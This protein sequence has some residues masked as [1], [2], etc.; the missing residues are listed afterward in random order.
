MNF[1]ILIFNPPTIRKKGKLNNLISLPFFFLVLIMFSACDRIPQ[2]KIS[3]R[4]IKQF[5]TNE[6]KVQLEKR[7]VIQ[8]EEPFTIRNFTP[9]GK[10]K[11]IGQAISYGPYRV[12]QAPGVKGPSEEEILEDLTIISKYWNLIRVYNADDDTERILKVIHEHQFPIK[13]MLGVWLENETD[14]PEKRAANS[15]NIVRAI[16]MAKKY[17]NV[18]VAI[19]VGN[20]TQVFWSWHKMD[21]SDLI[22]YIRAIREYTQIPVTTADDYNFWNKPESKQVADEVDFIVTHI[23]PLWNGKTLDNSIKWLDDT[24]KIV[25][26]NHPNRQL[27]LGEIGWATQYNAE[28]K[29]DGQQGTLIK[30]KVGIKAQQT[31]LIELDEWINKNK[32]P[33]FLFEAFDEPWKGGGEHTGT[34]EVEKNWGVF[35]ENRKPKQSFISF[36]EYKNKIKKEKL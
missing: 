6:I 12:G 17:K 22:R 10:G 23:Y 34:S 7:Q 5:D 20:E 3:D 36:L 14:K 25:Q 27:V 29:G 35:Y 8:K 18:L 31:F 15:K 21:T 9:Y 32:V 30:G 28:K 26:N 1:I 16:E 4:E 33:T 11:W 19:N 13:V 24:Y 2:D